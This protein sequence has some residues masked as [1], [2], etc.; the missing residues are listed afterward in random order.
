MQDPKKPVEPETADTPAET[1]PRTGG[2]GAFA[3]IYRARWAATHPNMLPR[4]YTKLMLGK[5]ETTPLEPDPS[6]V[7]TEDGTRLFRIEDPS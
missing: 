7:H 4:E 2:F 3:D 1:A 5:R 6:R